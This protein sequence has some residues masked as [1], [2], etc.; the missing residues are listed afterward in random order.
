V[1]GD[2]TGDGLVDVADI[3]A[4]QYA[5]NSGASDGFY[6][7]DSNGAVNHDDLVFLVEDLI[8][9]RMGD[10]NLDGNVDATDFNIWNVNHFQDDCMSWSTAD[11]NGDG[12]VDGADFNIWNDNKFQPVPAAADTGDEIVRPPRAALAAHINEGFIHSEV[13]EVN[14]ASS[15][16]VFRE[17][18]ALR[19]N[20]AFH[21]ALDLQ[22]TDEQLIHET[23]FAE[24]TARRLPTWRY[25]SLQ[26]RATGSTSAHEEVFGTELDDWLL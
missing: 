22:S 19:G 10:A 15:K 8:G 9:R 5:L 18:V 6:D 2:I 11:F 17:H 16:A 24:R 3:G 4:F 23:V 13:T 21:R 20:L 12:G 26:T 14:G 1:A 7:L 25:D